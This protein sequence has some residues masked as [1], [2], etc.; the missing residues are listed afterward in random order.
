MWLFDNFLTSCIARLWLS[1]VNFMGGIVNCFPKDDS[2]ENEQTKKLL[3]KEEEQEDNNKLNNE[4]IPNVKKQP[5]NLLT[6]ENKNKNN[7][8]NKISLLTP[9]EE[10]LEP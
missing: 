6:Q 2:V 3:K 7:T 8:T 10:A 5:D 9:V 1:F 4:P